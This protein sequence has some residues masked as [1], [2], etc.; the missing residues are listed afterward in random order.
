VVRVL[1]GESKKLRH[2]HDIR[3]DTHAPKICAQ[4]AHVAFGHINHLLPLPRF[5]D[6]LME[7]NMVL[8]MCGDGDWGET[9]DWR[10]Y[11]NKGRHI[12]TINCRQGALQLLRFFHSQFPLPILFETY[13]ELYM[14]LYMCVEG[15]WGRHHIFKA[16]Q[17]HL[18][19][20]ICTMNRAQWAL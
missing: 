19:R 7:F 13:M 9:I 8:Y 12:C 5:F 15:C 17:Q 6:T 4:G 1:G 10:H 18:G 20:H 16:L 3:E 2:F 14:V 11:N